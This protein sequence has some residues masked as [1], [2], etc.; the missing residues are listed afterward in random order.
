MST[1]TESKH[2]F[3]INQ[4][5][6]NATVSEIETW[7]NIQFQLHDTPTTLECKAMNLSYKFNT[8]YSVDKIHTDTNTVFNLIP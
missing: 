5:K 7:L 4:S 2:E 8:K 6:V 3:V 1:L